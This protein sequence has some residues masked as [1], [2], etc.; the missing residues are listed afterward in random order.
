VNLNAPYSYGQNDNP[1]M[2]YAMIIIAAVILASNHIVARYMNG[3]IPPMG[4]VFW[5]MV[6]GACV[7]LPFAGLGLFANR[8]LIF[9]H[10]KLFLIL[11]VL[12]VP[13]GNGIIYAAYSFTTALNGGVV[14]ASQPAITVAL[15]WLLFRDVINWKQGIGILIAATGVLAIIGRGDPTTLLSL[16]FNIGDL[17]M[18]VAIGFV[19]LHNVLLRLVPKN[20][21]TPQLL[22]TIQLFGLLVGGP[23]YLAETLLYRPVPVTYESVAALF[24]IGI[25]V[26]AIAVGL[27]NTA[28][29]IIGANKASIANYLRAGFTAILAILLLGET[30]QTFHAVGLILVT[31]GVLLMS[32]GRSKIPGAR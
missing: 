18:V 1:A 20:I 25:A 14:S 19:A 5:R 9:K 11:G 29:R 30:I 15:S 28:V 7:L 23:L 10:W 3:V 2:P 27:T 24:W 8:A 6:I 21:N 31:S 13:L 26:T 12:F 32:R 22:L 16:R 17:M 4:M